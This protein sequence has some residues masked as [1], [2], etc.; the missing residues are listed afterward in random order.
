MR[1]QVW[2]FVASAVAALLTFGAALR[3]HFL[4]ALLWSLVAVG[5][6]MTARHW[7]RKAPEPFPHT[8][9]WLLRLPRPG[10][11]PGQLVRI[12]QP[13]V[14]E[15]LLEV[16]PGIG[17]HALPIAAALAPD[18]V[19]DVLDVQQEMLETVR[20]R[21]RAAGIANLT[22]CA[23]DAAH[24]PYPDARFDGA[25]L[26][27]V[28]GE[29]PDG[30]GTLRELSRV[31][32]PAGRLVI[33]ELLIDPDFVPFRRLRLRAEHAGFILRRKTG[34]AVA[35]FARFEHRDRGA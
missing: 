12:L 22:G 35:Y 2:V 16:G 9:R 3:L 20:R 30:D 14:G 11:S 24:L 29:I 27:S 25:Y 8:F 7:N 21:A 19:L 18:G 4:W 28:F 17:T 13:R 32:K 23:G 31:L 1:P 15:R 26:I 6:W 34:G 10:H 33:G 5:L